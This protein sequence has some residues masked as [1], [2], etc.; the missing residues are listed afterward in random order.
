MCCESRK[1]ERFIDANVDKEVVLLPL[2]V[3]KNLLKVLNELRNCIDAAI[4][5]GDICADEIT[6]V[7][8]Y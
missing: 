3:K 1:P 6:K 5:C 8:K 4:F 2:L 7:K